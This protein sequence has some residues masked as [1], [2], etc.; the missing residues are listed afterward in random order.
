MQQDDKRNDNTTNL[1]RLAVANLIRRQS[2]TS[3]KDVGHINVRHEAG[4]RS[5][6]LEK[7]ASSSNKSFCLISNNYCQIAVVAPLTLG[8][9]T[10][11]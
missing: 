1:D 3:S 5:A 2:D 11:D 10:A 8:T 7:S 6:Q 4:G 9:P